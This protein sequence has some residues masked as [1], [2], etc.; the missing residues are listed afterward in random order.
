MGCVGLNLNFQNVKAALNPMNRIFFYNFVEHYR[1]YYNF[2]NIKI[3]YC[4]VFELLAAK[5]VIQGVFS[6]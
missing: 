5:I 3:N 2:N 6:M 4:G 1:T